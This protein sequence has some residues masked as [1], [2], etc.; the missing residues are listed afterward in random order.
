MT[1]MTIEELKST[2][3]RYKANAANWRFNQSA[4]KGYESLIKDEGILRYD[5]DKRDSEDIEYREMAAWGD[6]LSAWT[7]E[8][9]ADFV[10]SVPFM[11]DFSPL[12]DDWAFERFM[13]DCDMDET[14]WGVFWDNARR[15][16]YTTGMQGILVDKGKST[17]NVAMDK[18]RG[19]YPY[20]VSFS[21]LAILKTERKRDEYSNRPY[22]SYL[23]YVESDGTYK[24]W[25]TEEWKAYKIIDEEV[26]LIDA[27]ENQIGE[28][29]FFWFYNLKSLEDKY[30]GK[31][32]IQGISGID[33]SIISETAD[34]AQV[35][36]A[37]G[38]LML[39]RPSSAIREDQDLEVGPNVQIAFD[40]DNPGG[41]R[42]FWLTPDVQGP[43]NAAMT[44][45]E[46]QEMAAMRKKNLSSVFATMAKDAR[47]A[48]SISQAFRFL[49]SSL[50]RKVNNELEAR[51][52][53]ILYWLKW[54]NQS[55]LYNGI[56]ITHP[57][58]YNIQSL[59][60]TIQDAMTAKTVVKSSD[61]FQKYIDKMIVKKVSPDISQL[62]Y[63]EIAD[64]IDSAE[65]I[66]P[67]AQIET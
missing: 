22:L 67:D 14:D 26:V 27:G 2:D 32:E 64:E 54:Q 28:I 17:G 49:E 38:F 1:E 31:S 3:D 48:E 25:T 10:G 20:L 51:N 24:I 13:R 35:F 60:L 18:E 29:P 58:S 30:L 39:A 21:P 43:V 62:E 57:R 16:A 44:I 11:E 36:R 23:K 65:I 50:N 12:V 15:A 8:L 6:D 7:V 40:A 45:I 55:D 42:P 46:K 5:A 4:Y 53:A 52:K 37:A 19:V 59:I 9:F 34:V 41:T 66:K 56:S 61:R 33:A 63:K 47:S